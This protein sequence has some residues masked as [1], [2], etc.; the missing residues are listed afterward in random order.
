[1]NIF[2]RIKIILL[3]SVAGVACDQYTK[4]LATEY[5]RKTGMDSYFNDFF[6][7][8]Y[9]EN[10]GAFLG[11]GSNLPENYRFGIFVIAVGALLLG[12][13]IYLVLNARQTTYSLVG[14]SLVFS[15]G[16]SNFYDRVVNN[17]AVVDF[18]NIGFGPIR[19]GVFNIADMFILFGLLIFVITPENKSMKGS[20]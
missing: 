19:T 16:L 2:K 20:G 13:L 3:V 9:T 15:G 5:L 17:G 10:I 4:A 7:I 14:L 12:L 18:L 11:V 6:R 1:M 8:G